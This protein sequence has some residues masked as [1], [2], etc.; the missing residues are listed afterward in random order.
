MSDTQD[1]SRES[2]ILM[3]PCSGRQCMK[4]SI[5]VD[6]QYSLEKEVN[7]HVSIGTLLQVMGRHRINALRCNLSPG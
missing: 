7:E 1:S 5:F 2:R 4:R 6:H 3:P